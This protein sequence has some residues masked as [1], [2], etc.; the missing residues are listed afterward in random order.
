MQ[1]Q[2][3]YICP[4]CLD[5][6]DDVIAE[7]HPCK[8]RFHKV[9][10][11]K[12]HTYAEDLKC[13]T[14]RVESQS[15]IM[16]YDIS[17]RTKRVNINLRKGFDIKTIIDNQGDELLRQLNEN[18]NNILQLTNETCRSRQPRMRV[19]NLCG[20][21]GIEVNKYC[22]S[23]ELFFHESCLRSLACEIGARD[24]WEQC[25]ECRAPVS[26]LC[27]TRNDQSQYYDSRNSIIFE[28]RVRER[29]SVA[30]ERL[31]RWQTNIEGNDFNK[32]ND[33]DQ[34]DEE[35]L[36]RLREVKDKIQRHVRSALET[37]CNFGIA[38]GGI[39]RKHFTDVNKTVSRK[40]YR[41]SRYM[42]QQ[43]VIDYDLEA[44]R[45]VCIELNKLG[46]A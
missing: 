36:S 17:D 11:R 22:D 6:G 42:Y 18:F 14:C 4:I 30:T 3:E 29:N 26:Q 12:W 43:G 34:V 16:D 40:L 38:G 37:Y 20:E 5:S 23:C 33:I 44:Q 19:C 8:H 7:L 15:L 31:Y 27:Y 35:E 28:G 39:D 2:E 46:Y 21:D 41:V 13:P 10:I 1:N 9:C 45:E 32:D 25:V 24:S